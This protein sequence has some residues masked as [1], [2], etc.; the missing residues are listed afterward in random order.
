MAIVAAGVSGV[1]HR[2]SLPPKLEERG[3]VDLPSK[4]NL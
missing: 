3:R 2:L 1:E 4:S